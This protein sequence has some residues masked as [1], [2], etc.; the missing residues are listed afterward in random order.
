[1]LA[2][3]DLDKA[4]DRLEWSFIHHTLLYYRFPQKLVNL[5]MSCISTTPVSILI[6]ARLPLSFCLPKESAKEILGLLI[7]LFILC[8]ER[9]YCKIDLQSITNFGVLLKLLLVHLLFLI[10][11]LLMTLFFMQL[12]TLSLVPPF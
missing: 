11:C 12:L 4:F 9:L 8:M 2:K 5:T 3:I 6:M 7:Y 1:M 10:Y